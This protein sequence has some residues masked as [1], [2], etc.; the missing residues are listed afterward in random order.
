MKK[1]LTNAAAAIVAVMFANVVRADQPQ[2]YLN[3]DG[4]V[5]Q[6]VEKLKA[7]VASL[8]QQLASPKTAACTVCGDDCACNPGDCP[9]KCPVASV[10]ADL[11]RAS[12]HYETRCEVDTFG[13]KTRCYQVW[14]P[15][16]AATPA[17]ASVAIPAATVSDGAERRGIFP[18]FPN[19]PRLFGGWIRGVRSGGCSSC[20]G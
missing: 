11:P 3:A 17:S 12:G 13:R 16:A 14:V 10:G 7:E 1:M 15:D 9:G 2:F 6:R 19:R 20:G 4:T 18:L 8:K 5:E